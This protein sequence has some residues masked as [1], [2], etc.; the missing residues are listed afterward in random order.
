M[1]K[2][3]GTILLLVAMVCVAVGPLTVAE[4]KPEESPNLRWEHYTLEFA[5]G[6][7]A[8]FAGGTLAYWLVYSSQAHVSGMAPM[9]GWL[10]IPIG[11]L[12]G[13]S[14]GVIGTGW[15]LGNDENVAKVLLTALGAAVGAYAGFIGADSAHILS[16]DSE[17]TLV[18]STGLATAVPAALG[19]V[20]GYNLSFP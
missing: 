16:Y 8:G 20:I 13:A 1:L 4:P 17:L 5:A 7:F 15:A 3:M 12:I 2:R 14:T 18:I 6:T 11:S 10:S 19:A 9:A